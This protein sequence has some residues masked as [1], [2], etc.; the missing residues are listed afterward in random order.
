MCQAC[1]G[2]GT[3]K[4]YYNHREM[5]HDCQACEGEGVL[6]PGGKPKSGKHQPSTQA[7]SVPDD[8]SVP[9]LET[10]ED[11][12]AEARQAPGAHPASLLEQESQQLAKRRADALRH[13]LRKMDARIVEY[14]AELRTVSAELINNVDEDKQP[15][16]EELV[17]QLR[18]RIHSIKE[19][20]ECKQGKLD[21]LEA[22]V[23]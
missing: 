6:W 3:V 20:R 14:E 23:H 17:Q 13:T 11:E 4:E 19:Q 8:D 15:L 16:L 21:E 7:S 5:Q 12:G 1:Q 9:P 18:R 22:S 2:L 10:V